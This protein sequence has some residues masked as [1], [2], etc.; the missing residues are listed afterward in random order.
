MKAILNRYLKLLGYTELWMLWR[1]S[2]EA[3]T[4]C[5]MF[6]KHV[7][8]RKTGVLDRFLEGIQT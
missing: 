6:Q 3:N 4:D 1:S 5:G 8:E 7:T 2:Q